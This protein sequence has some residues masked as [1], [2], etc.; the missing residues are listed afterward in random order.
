MEDIKKTHK[1]TTGEKVERSKK[2]DNPNKKKKKASK[3]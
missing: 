1:F 2:G 3:K